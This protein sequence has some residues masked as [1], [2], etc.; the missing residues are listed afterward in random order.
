MSVEIIDFDSKYRDDFKILNEEWLNKYFVIECFD[1]KQLENPESEILEKGGKIFFAKEGEK[2]IG[3]ASL[4]FHNHNYELAKMAVTEGYKGQGIGNL[5]MQHCV[6]HAKK[7]GAEKVILLSNKKLVPAISM[8]RKFG[9][10]EVEVDPEN[11][12]ERCDI[13]MELPLQ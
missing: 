13:K 1:Q 11:P 7:L 8:Y 3:T 2:I 6:E 5:L 10:E 12:Y 9:F 4:L